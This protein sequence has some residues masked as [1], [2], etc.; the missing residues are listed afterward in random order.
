MKTNDENVKKKVVI[1]ATGGTI[2]GIGERGK[3]VRYEPGSLPVGDLINAIPEIKDVAEIEAIQICNVNSDDMTDEIWFSLAN[4]INEMA[5]EED[6]SGFVVTHGTDT[7]E[8]TAYFLN[9]TVK[10]NKTSDEVYTPAYAVKPLVKYVETFMQ[11]KQL[12]HVMI[13]CPFDMK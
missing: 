7:L 11:R 5:I 1:L 3:S 2:A 6:I 4:T 12:N 8:E 9:L 13:W 10:T